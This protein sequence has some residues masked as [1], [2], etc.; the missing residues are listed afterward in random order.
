[1]AAAGSCWL[2]AVSLHLGLVLG[3]YVCCLMLQQQQQP[4]TAGLR[5]MLHP[6]Y[7]SHSCRAE[8]GRHMPAELIS[9]HR[10]ISGDI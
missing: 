2:V 4:L 8:Q 7:K 5:V 9:R 6:Q 1:M 3:A 10:Q